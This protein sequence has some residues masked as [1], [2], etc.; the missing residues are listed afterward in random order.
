MQIRVEAPRAAHL[1]DVVNV[2]LLVLSKRT[3]APMA[4]GAA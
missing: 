2:I 1:F 3:L 4:G